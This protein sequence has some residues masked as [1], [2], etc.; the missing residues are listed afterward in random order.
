MNDDERTQSRAKMLQKVAV[1]P[2]AIG[3]FAAL[4]AQAEADPMIDQKAADYVTHPVG[5][6]QC[7]KCAFYRPAKVAPGTA[8]GACNLV[9]G[10][11]L[12]QG[13]CKYFKEKS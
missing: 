13:Y 10:T 4:Q 3:A 7:S 12:P 9:K 11:I 1:A 6:K 5:D 8:P 2:I